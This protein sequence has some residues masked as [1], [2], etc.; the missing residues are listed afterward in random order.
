LFSCLIMCSS[1]ES[2]LAVNDRRIGTKMETWVQTIKRTSEVKGNPHHTY[3]GSK[4]CGG[5]AVEPRNHG[6]YD[7]AC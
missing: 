3:G 5:F 7:D 6:S 4:K 2:N 1:M